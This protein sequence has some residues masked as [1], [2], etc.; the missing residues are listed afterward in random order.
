MFYHKSNK[1]ASQLCA[2]DYKVRRRKCRGKHEPIGM[3]PQVLR[4]FN[5]HKTSQG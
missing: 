3:K 1:K 5:S 2:L 4:K